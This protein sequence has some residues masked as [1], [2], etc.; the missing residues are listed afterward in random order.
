MY[1]CVYVYLFAI[2]IY[3]YICMHYIY[4]KDNSKSGFVLVI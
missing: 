2:C 3:M 4:T 1:I